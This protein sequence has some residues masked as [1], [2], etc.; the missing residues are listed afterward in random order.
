MSNRICK[1]FGI[2]LPIIQAP[3]HTLTNGKMIASIAEAG[4]L[5]ILGINSGFKFETD[6][7]TGASTATSEKIGDE[8]RFSILDTMTERN[9]MNEQIDVAL[10]NTFRP[11][12]VEIA[13]TEASPNDDPTAQSLVMLMRKRRITITLFESWGQPISK[14]WISLL[15]GNG[16]KIMEKVE[17][18][19]QAQN[20]QKSGVDVLIYI[21]N[22]L[23][24]FVKRSGK[25]TPI[26][27]GKNVTTSAAI[28]SAFTNGADGIFISTPFVVCEEAPTAN[29][30]KEAIIKSNSTN[31][32]TFT[33][34][35]ETV[36]SLPGTLPNKLHDLTITKIDS[37]EIFK[38]AHHF[39]GLINGM[40]KGDLANGYTVLDE[41]IDEIKKIAPAE[42]IIENIAKNI[43]EKSR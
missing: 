33:F 2:S 14:E 24:N 35:N 19:E 18:I 28:K 25:Q 29:N 15:H 34:P 12:A 27:A 40:V 9:L 36:Y 42:E 11:F 10:E 16:I 6:A 43:P 4:A 3:I 32:T 5:G 17:T 1:I 26:L 22:D 41:N 39:Q 38:Q 21:G 23:A 13:S 37:S 7:S 30:I 8:E 31:L 20:A